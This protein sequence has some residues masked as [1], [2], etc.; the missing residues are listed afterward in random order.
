MT[1]F[2][3]VVNFNRQ[4]GVLK[5]DELKPNPNIFDTD[6][7]TVEQCLKLVNEEHKELL[8]AI[9]KK[10]FIQVIDAI[11]DSIYV[12]LG[13]SSRFG[14]DMD[15]AFRL[16]HDNNMSKFCKTEE[17][18]QRSVDNYLKKK[19]EWNATH[20]D[21]YPYDKPSYRKAVDNIHWIVFNEVDN[22]V[23]KSIE[24]VDVNLSS[25]CK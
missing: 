13:M 8:D 17:E 15:E 20:E 1:Y 24:W 7:T 2:E 23:L 22:K 4:F 12:L 19:E 14:V 11:G 21:R 6:P 16:I 5:S 10:D 25:V 3:R 9:E 18:A